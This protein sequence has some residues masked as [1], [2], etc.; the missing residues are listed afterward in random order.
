MW[1]FR[2]H[3][4]KMYKNKPCDPNGHKALK[5]YTILDFWVGGFL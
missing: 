1:A 3:D 4:K 5:Q 2:G